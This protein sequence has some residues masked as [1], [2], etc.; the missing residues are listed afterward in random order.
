MKNV[1][2][3]LEYYQ[4]QIDEIMLICAS[5]VVNHPNRYGI[6]KMISDRSNQAAEQASSNAYV[7]GTLDADKA[8][9]KGVE[10]VLKSQ[11]MVGSA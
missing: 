8:V 2:D 9:Q 7:T 3:P 11:R 10:A 6:L 5:L 1:K 4:G